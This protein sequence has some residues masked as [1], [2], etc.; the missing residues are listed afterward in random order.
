MSTQN[1]F[2]YPQ[3]AYGQAVGTT[4][5]GG[6]LL[7][8]RDPTTNDI[9]YK[10]GQ[11]WQNTTDNN[12]WYL[13][14][15]TASSGTLL[16]NWTNIVAGGVSVDSVVMQTGTS[17]V[18]PDGSGL[19]TF[20][21]AVVAAGTNP[22]RTDGTGANTMA[23]EVQTSQALAATDA[24]KIGLANFNSAHFSVDANGFVGLLGGSQA[25]DSVAVQ[26]GTSPILPT[27]AGL[28]TL[29]GAVVA[30]G[31]N[32]IRTDGTGANTAAVEVQISQALAATDATKIGLSNFNSS[33]FSVD[34][35]GFVS[36]SGGGQ[37]I[38]SFTPS[39]GTTPVGPDGTGNIAL[40]AGNGFAFTGGTNALTGNMVTPFLGQ[41]IFQNN[42]ASTAQL[43]A[44]R[45]TDTNA[46]STASV[47]SSVVGASSADAFYNCAIEATISYAVGI[48]NS[49]SQ[50][51]K[52]ASAAN[53]NATPSSTALVKIT[54][55]GAMTKPLQPAFSAYNSITRSNVTGDGTL[56]TVIFNTEQYDQATNFDGISTFT[57]PVTGI[58]HFDAQIYMNGFDAGHTSAGCEILA[59]GVTYN[60][61][62][63][64][65][66]NR[67]DATGTLMLSISKDI[68][69]TA[70]Q[71]AVVNV[72][73]SG[74]TKTN[75][76]TNQAVDSYFNGHLIC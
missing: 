67:A 42:T 43:L 26:T 44:S 49:D 58:Y 3:Q 33:H 56:Y 9:N 7:F 75:S 50:S 61:S 57:A 13:N 69:L 53:S 45:N 48:D 6:I 10:I 8:T 2:Q 20:N 31:T 16:A 68:S 23:L 11:Q 18:V 65:G 63:G 40:P 22:V 35:N 4:S 54:T 55:L 36:L 62:Q 38:D 46:A 32:P 14:S 71:T 59:G 60:G 19:L 27:V 51:F 1:S 15:F 64:G 24:T 74:G 28:V 41:F 30:A 73:V 21:G 52:I 47:S 25:V 37:A 76:V 66:F 5:T 39:S 70:S 34:A 72:T 17:P 29:N 12:L